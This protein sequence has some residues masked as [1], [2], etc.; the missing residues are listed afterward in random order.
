[1]RVL[2]L[3]FCLTLLLAPVE[4][5]GTPVDGI[6]DPSFGTVGLARIDPD[7]AGLGI[8][9]FMRDFA[10]SPTS[11]G[12]YALGSGGDLTLA[13]ITPNGALDTGFNGDGYATQMPALPSIT[14]FFPYR[15]TV[16]ANGK[17]VVAGSANE[18]EGGLSDSQGLVCRFNV[19]GNPD[20]SF[21]GDGCR[22]FEL[23]F[24]SNHGDDLVRAVWSLPDD[25]LLIVGT[26]KG[27]TD[28]DS[29][30][31]GFIA[32]LKAD[33]S[34]DTDFGL[35]GL[36]WLDFPLTD[37]VVAEQ[38][39]VGADGRI[40]VGGAR[41][42]D[43]LTQA[44]VAAFDSA[45]DP[46]PDYGNDG[47]AEFA[48]AQEFPN[49]S[50][51]GQ[52]TTGLVVDGGGRVTH[53]G[54]A[55]DFTTTTLMVTLARL[56]GNGQPDAGFDGDGRLITSYTELHAVNYTGP[57]VLDRHGRLTLSMHTGQQ[58]SYD[59][60]LALMRFRSDGS[61]DED[62]HGSGRL[63]LPLNLGVNGNGSELIGGF[64]A[65]GDDLVIAGT[66]THQVW[67]ANPDTPYEFVALRLRDDRM[68][69]DGF[70]GTD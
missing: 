6:V 46:L 10:R 56:D 67:N 33:G 63:A 28:L 4:F 41:R 8:G 18:L 29:A 19:A 34:Y 69:S 11:G 30:Q 57:C 55:R 2:T 35:G 45:G 16:S 27:L 3:P 12:F 38:I 61:T 65:Q 53:C 31:R 48:F 47:I 59:P 5:A 25:R 52:Y 9:Q 22:L 64:V 15:L 20:T 1:M 21:D 42:R 39:A 60:E 13:R 68:F 36:R 43:Q 70:E 37:F 62:F 44:F 58:G 51:I 7:D 17:P 54:H 32:K 40:Y 49:P 24:E 23:D 66:A 26:A 14:S 50:S